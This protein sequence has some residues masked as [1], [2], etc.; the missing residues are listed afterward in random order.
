MSGSNAR[1]PSLLWRLFV[2]GGV[3]TMTALSTNRKAWEA[4]EDNV[5]DAVPR[6]AIQ[7]ALLGTVGLH[8][9]EASAAARMADRRGVTP[10]RPWVLSTL[11]YGFPVLNRLRRQPASA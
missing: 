9:L 8:V 1:R 11:A 5:T 10:A 7:T 4:W 6:S 2:L 3:A